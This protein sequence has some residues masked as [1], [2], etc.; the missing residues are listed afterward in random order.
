MK[1]VNWMNHIAPPKSELQANSISEPEGERI[2]GEL[3]DFLNRNKIVS[4]FLDTE[5]HQVNVDI[6]PRLPQRIKSVLT[7]WGSIYVEDKD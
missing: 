5:N 4:I 3:I 2:R 7:K 1:T 6:A